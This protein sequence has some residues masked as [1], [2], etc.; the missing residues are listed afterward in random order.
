MMTW[1]SAFI[2][3]GLALLLSL[4][5]LAA[6]WRLRR[7]WRAP[8]IA[9]PAC[10]RCRY[11]IDDPGRAC[12]ECGADL[13]TMGVVDAAWSRR[14]IRFIRGAFVLRSV[15]PL[16]IVVGGVGPGSPRPCTARRS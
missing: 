13:A 1:I 8:A 16:P 12:S 2:V 9:R 4:V 6:L 7:R 11:A 5:G 15:L 14:R 10:P 3:P